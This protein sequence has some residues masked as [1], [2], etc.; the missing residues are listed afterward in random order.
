MLPQIT[1]QVVWCNVYPFST[2]LYFFPRLSEDNNSCRYGSG[3]SFYKHVCC[4]C[5]LGILILNRLLQ[6]GYLTF[7][8]HVQKVEF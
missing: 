8:L 4:T 7:F 6:I 5:T 2:A 1:T 3:S